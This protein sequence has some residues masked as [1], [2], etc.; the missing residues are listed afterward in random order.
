MEFREI[1][2]PSSEE[3]K[4]II[5]AKTLAA[6]KIN[7]DIT[8]LYDLD[9]EK[10]HDE[11]N[12]ILLEEEKAGYEPRAI[13]KGTAIFIRDLGHLLGIVLQVLMWMTPIMWDVNILNSHPWVIRLFKLNPMYYVVTGYRD[14]FINGDSN[15]YM[16]VGRGYDD[17]DE[18]SDLSKGVMITERASGIAIVAT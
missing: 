17:G 11:Y 13:V 18:I 14:A 7:D 9:K 8:C 6:H 4:N 12:F 10:T 1:L 16:A 15:L 5:G 3:L 2:N